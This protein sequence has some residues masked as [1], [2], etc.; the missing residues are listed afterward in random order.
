MSKC[1]NFMSQVKNPLD[2]IIKSFNIAE[3]KIR[4]LEDITV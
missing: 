3:V 1:L 4:E 2:M